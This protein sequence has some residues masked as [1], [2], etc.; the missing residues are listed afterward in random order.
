VL[1][2]DE[3]LKYIEKDFSKNLDKEFGE[4]LITAGAGDIDLL[5]NPIKQMLEKI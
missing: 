3:V 5:V 1:T 4:V 2:K